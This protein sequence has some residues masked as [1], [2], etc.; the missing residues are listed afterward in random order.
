MQLKKQN[1]GII[2]ILVL[3]A[4]SLLAFVVISFATRITFETK[5]VSSTKDRTQAL[6]INWNAV[7]YLRKIVRDD[8]EN[9]DVIS[10]TWNITPD[11]PKEFKVKEGMWRIEEGFDEESLINVNEAGFEILDR[12]F[13]DYPAYLLCLLDWLY[14]DYIPTT[15]TN[16][17]K[18]QGYQGAEKDDP[19]YLEQTYF[20]RNGK[21][22]SLMELMMVK[23]AEALPAKRAKLLPPSRNFFIAEALASHAWDNEPP[24]FR[25]PEDRRIFPPGKDIPPGHPEEPPQLPNIPIIPPS[26][27]GTGLTTYGDGRVNINTA[28]SPVLMALGFQPETVKRILAYRLYKGIFENTEAEYIIK[29]LITKDVLRPGEPN[30]QNIAN[31]IAGVVSK[32]RLKVNSEYFRFQIVSLTEHGAV[33]KAMVVFKREVKYI[34]G[35]KVK[36]IKIITWWDDYF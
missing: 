28:G 6:F 29:E 33:D 27:Q 34:N 21:M 4:V 17:P 31:N 16:N 3:A 25:D 11:K 15:I 13:G 26:P 32:G 14:S 30:F 22:R 18:Y 12:I 36:K 20:P 5:M 8:A 9:T 19:F 10:D 1:K 24:D 35:K 2:S 23:G 7:E